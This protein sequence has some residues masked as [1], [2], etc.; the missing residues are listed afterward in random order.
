MKKTDKKIIPIILAS[1]LCAAA[2]T[3]CGKKEETSEKLEFNG[4]PIRNSTTLT[5]WM[6]LNGN[7]A[8]TSEDEGKTRFAEELKNETG[9][10][11]KWIHPPLGQASDQLN[12]LLTSDDLP[13]IIEYGWESLPGGGAKALEDNFIINLGDKMKENAPN[14]AKYLSENPDIDK[15]I[16]TDN[17]EYYAFPCIA[18]D[19]KM[20]VVQG[21]IVRKDW[22]D[23]LGLSM[24]ETIDEWHNVLTQFKEKKGAAAP[25][26]YHD[27]MLRN[28]D[29]IGAYGIKMDFFIENGKVVYGPYDRRYKDF[30]TTFA[31][32][33]KEG[34]ID[35]NIANLD[36]KSLDAKILNGETGA[37]FSFAGS[38][39]GKWQQALNAKNSGAELAPAPHITLNKGETAQ[40]G[41][42]N[43]MATTYGAAIT[44]SC[45]NVDLA[46]R[47]LDY[48]YS[49]KGRMLYNFGIE[50]ESY[51]MVDNYPTY[52]D[53][54]MKNPEGLSM[55]AAMGKYIRGNQTG[56]FI[57]A[58]EYLEQYYSLPQQKDALEVWSKSEAEKTN[59]PYINFTA[60]ESE[61]IAS[62][63]N[64]VKTYVDE[65]TLRYIMG[66]ENLD[67]FDGYIADIKNF[68]MDKVLDIYQA[69]YERYLAR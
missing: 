7:V 21:P 28:G 49:E 43:F 18:E 13:D 14:L 48:G 45:K 24:P 5:Y 61:E 60:N 2:V 25:L 31:Q 53:V 55:G 47:F 40:F 42:K 6:E 9:V 26:A 23:E 66:L 38:G 35:K 57:Q 52:T 12:I 4:Y 34:L 8:E 10:D 54:I 19:K 1:V 39:L 27:N 3:G 15:L 44:S 36:S 63:L 33:Y 59:V 67:G 68:G 20:L 56:P 37:T 32:W 17:N 11:I 50:G 58:K 46:M 29:F 65:K 16:K 51:N 41:Q 22:L 69:A 30:L 64:N 62:I